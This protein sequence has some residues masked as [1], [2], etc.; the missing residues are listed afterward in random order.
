MIKIYDKGELPKFEETY[1]VQQGDGKYF[2]SEKLKKAIELAL[3]LNK[4]LLIAGEPGTGK[5]DAA[6]HIA[7]HF[8][9]KKEK[10]LVFNTQTTS[11]AK[12]LLYT[13]NS[14]AH[15]Q[16][17]RNEKADILGAQDLLDKKYI[18]YNPL[19]EA[20]INSKKGIRNV[21]LIDEIDKAPR[22]LP[23][24]MLDILEN[25]RFTVDELKINKKEKEP[26]ISVIEGKKNNK[27]IVILTT[28]SEKTLP[29]PFLRRCI[30]FYINF[31]EVDLETILNNKLDFK[32]TPTQWKTIIKYFKLLRKEL[33]GKKPATAELIMWAWILRKYEIT[34]EML[35]GT[36]EIGNKAE[37]LKSSYS[38]LI[39]DNTDWQTINNKEI[40]FIAKKM[41]P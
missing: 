21:V 7:Q 15:F 32:Y 31:D 41:K 27:P 18:T 38:V 33:T 10:P 22:D 3:W 19:G 37:L 12:D 39:K 34:P 35:N 17:S 6:Y 16:Y 24:D 29:E 26:D 1:N 23:N 4:P 40:D 36:K 8:L 2:P 28:N 20:I 5:T 11:T 30:F 25:M 14:L 9:G 13:Y